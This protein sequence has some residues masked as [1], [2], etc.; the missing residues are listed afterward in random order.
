MEGRGLR[1]EPATGRGAVHSRR[2]SNAL[3]RAEQQGK[4]FG[5]APAGRQ[6][7]EGIGGA[8]MHH[9][10]SARKIL[11]RVPALRERC[12][13][14]YFGRDGPACFGTMDCAS[15]SGLPG[16]GGRWQRKR[17]E[18]WLARVAKHSKPSRGANRRGGEKPRGRNLQQAWQ[19]AAEGSDSRFRSRRRRQHA[20]AV[21]AGQSWGWTRDGHVGSRARENESYERRT[22]RESGSAVRRRSEEGARFKRAASRFLRTE[23]CCSEGKTLKTSWQQ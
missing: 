2:R 23:R 11:R 20:S 8:V 15:G 6:P 14:S 19:R 7:Q 9:R 4:T 12:L 5:S 22:R 1:Q 3:Q 16:G 18:P 21:K 10:L 17:S 13:G